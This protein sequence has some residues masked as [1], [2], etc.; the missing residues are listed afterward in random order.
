[1]VRV[2]RPRPWGDK[3]DLLGGARV[4]VNSEV[5]K[6]RPVQYSTIRHGVVA[7]KTGPRINATWLGSCR[8]SALSDCACGYHLLYI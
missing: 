5:L 2:L 1:M 3:D 8:L 4:A 7:A 6:V